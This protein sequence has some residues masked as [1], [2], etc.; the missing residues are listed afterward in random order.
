MQ[1]NYRFISDLKVFLETDCNQHPSNI[2]K[3]IQRLKIIIN[4][5]ERLKILYKDPLKNFTAKTAPTH[6]LALTFDEIRRIE[7]TGIT[8]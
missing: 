7:L 3:H 4:F 8:N 6:R 1:F 5:A 2:K